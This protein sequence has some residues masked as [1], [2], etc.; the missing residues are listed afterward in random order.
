MPSVAIVL[1]AAGAVALSAGTWL[2][3]GPAAALGVAGGAAVLFGIAAE[4]G[5]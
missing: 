2:A 4:R 1:Q 3:F 5:Q